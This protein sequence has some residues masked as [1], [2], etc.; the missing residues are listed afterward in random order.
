[1]KNHPMAQSFV[2]VD[3][4]C[5]RIT[6][7]RKYTEYIEVAG[8]KMDAF[9]DHVSNNW[10]STG[11]KVKGT[12][13]SS[14]L[15][16]KSKKHSETEAGIDAHVDIT[17]IFIHGDD[18]R[19]MYCKPESTVQ[20]LLQR[21]AEGYGLPLR[22]SRFLLNGSPLFLSSLGRKTA[23]DLKLADL[24]EITISNVQEISLERTT[25]KPIHKSEMSSKSKKKSTKNKKS[26]KKRNNKPTLA[27]NDTGDKLKEAHSIELT[28][29]FEEAEP[30]FKA[31]RQKLNNLTLERKRPKTKQSLNGRNQVSSSISVVHNPD[32]FGLGGKAGKTSYTVNVGQVEYLYKSSKRNSNHSKSSKQRNCIDLHGCTQD[33]AVKNLVNH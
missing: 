10:T 21:Y 30:I 28:K 16:L 17:L 1:M 8:R 20:S 7:M 18:R 4:I 11:K 19:E 9:V 25:P 26:R 13:N 23:M 12:N 31:I 15:T 14:G 27:L 6:H 33:Q 22:S 2:N 5:G 29:I 32:T 24:D 3:E